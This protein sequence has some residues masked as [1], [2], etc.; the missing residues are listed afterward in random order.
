MRKIFF[1]LIAIIAIT[2]VS[3]NSGNFNFATPDGA[4]DVQKHIINK[5]GDK[6]VYYL[7]VMGKNELSSELAV[8]SLKYVDADKSYKKGLAGGRISDEELETSF[9]Y[10]EGKDGKVKISELDFSV[11]PVKFEEAIKFITS[12]TD[13]YENF[14]LYDWTFEVNKDKKSEAS[15]VINATKKGESTSMEGRYEVT[16]YYTFNFE[17]KADGTIEYQ[18]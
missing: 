6:E 3:C 12:Q 4:L 18:E 10:K 1:S 17:M 2:F 15:F 11:I 7:N 13:E 14:Q 8:I 5:F 16:N 9:P